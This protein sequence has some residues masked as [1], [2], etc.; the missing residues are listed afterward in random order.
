MVLKHSP[1]RKWLAC[2]ETM[3]HVLMVIVDEAHCIL[4]WSGDF[5]PAYAELEKLQAFIPT[6]IPLLLTTTM[7]VNPSENVPP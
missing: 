5:R 1:F 6:N 7:D 4:Q 3:T 2:K